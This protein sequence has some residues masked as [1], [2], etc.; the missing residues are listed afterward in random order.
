M[1]Q[2]LGFIAVVVSVALL[3]HNWLAN[4][5]GAGTVTGTIKYDGAVPNLPK[6]DMGA[7][8]KCAAKHAT[9]QTSEALVLGAGNTM[10]NVL[11]SVKSGL[12]AGK[13]Y[14]T[15][16]EAVVIA[17]DGCL[18]KPH[19]FGVVKGQPLKFLNKDGTLH[20]V[21]ALPVANRPFNLSMPATMTESPPKDFAKVEDPFKIKCD[22]HP[23]MNTW[24]RVLDHP[25]FSVTKTE[26]TFAISGLDPGEY[27]IE[28]WH[29]KLGAQT[30]KVTVAA[31]GTA[32]ADFTFK[33]P[34]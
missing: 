25:F 31:G 18:Y 10:A 7:D 2:V 9:P 6:L 23:W 29:E 19:V 16:T 12:P 17:Q 20:N 32:T 1:R 5:Q 26:G 24:A 27:E 28:A 13:V 14:P 21:H 15:P 30:A 4:A 8:P 11:V 33:A 22:V 34:Q 3:S